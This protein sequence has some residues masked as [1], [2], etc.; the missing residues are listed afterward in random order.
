MKGEVGLVRRWAAL[1]DAPVGATLLEPH[2]PLDPLRPRQHTA[3]LGTHLLR[4]RA[5]VEVREGVAVIAVVM[6]RVLWVR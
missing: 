6:V 1:C 2:D 3:E 4:V 5:G